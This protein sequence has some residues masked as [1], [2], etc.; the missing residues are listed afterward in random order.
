[1]DI[2]SYC[3]WIFGMGGDC[4][5]RVHRIRST[6]SKPIFLVRYLKVCGNSTDSVCLNTPV[7]K[8]LETSNFQLTTHEVVSREV[9]DGAA[10]EFRSIR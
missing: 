4:L 10:A 5:P 6:A 1:M 9:V 3:S 7:E 8:L 2:E